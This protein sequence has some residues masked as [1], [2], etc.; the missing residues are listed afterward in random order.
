MPVH[1]NIKGPSGKTEH[2]NMFINEQTLCSSL[3]ARV[4][5]M[6]GIP[7]NI[8]L[9]SLGQSLLQPNVPLR[10]YDIEDG[11]WINLSITGLGGGGS[12]AGK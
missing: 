10:D 5:K 11:T 6:W 7:R 9:L 8:Q 1:L 4:E 12:D 3:Y 2:L